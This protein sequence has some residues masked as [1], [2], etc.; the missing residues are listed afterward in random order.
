MT[1]FCNVSESS[2]RPHARIARIK[3]SPELLETAELA[4]NQFKSEVKHLV[5]LEPDLSSSFQ[6]FEEHVDD[7]IV[8]L[9]MVTKVDDLGD[10]EV[11]ERGPR[12]RREVPE[13]GDGAG[14]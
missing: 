5:E 13:A 4:A 12:L 8:Y 10:L 1:S 9:R 14:P 2:K 3:S 11:V 7:S 6:G